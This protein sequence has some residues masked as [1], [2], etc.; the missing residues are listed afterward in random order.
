[1]WMDAALAASA[2]SKRQRMAKDMAPEAIA[3]DSLEECL[4]LSSESQKQ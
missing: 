4:S 3:R 2:P 1:M